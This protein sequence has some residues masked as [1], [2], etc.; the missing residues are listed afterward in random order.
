MRKRFLILALI[1]IA[2][3][4]LVSC[5]QG[6]DLLIP[7]A[8]SSVE[9]I[10]TLDELVAFCSRSGS[11]KA[12]LDLS[13]DSA[14]SVFPLN[15]TGRKE[16]SGK[17]NLLD[18]AAG[19][20]GLMF[21]NVPTP[22]ESIVIFKVEDGA[23]VTISDF[24]VDVPATVAEST[25]ITVVSMNN[26]VVTANNYTVTVTGSPSTPDTTPKVTGLAVGSQTA[27]GNVVVVNS[28]PGTVVVDENNT[29]DTAIRDNIT[30]SNP[31]SS[32][33]VVTKY[34]AATP[35]EF[36]NNLAEYGE[37]RLTAD[38][39]A[40]SI[41]VEG[42]D[43]Q[44]LIG[45]FT[46]LPEGNEYSVNLNG[47]S[48]QITTNYTVLVPSNSTMSFSDGTLNFIL[49]DA[50]SAISNLILNEGATLNLDNVDFVGNTAGI[51]PN[52]DSV[53]NVTNGSSVTAYSYGIATN[54][55][56]IPGTDTPANGDVTIRISNSRVESQNGCA[57]FLNVPGLLEIR[58]NSYI[59]GDGNAVIL[60]GGTGTIENSTLYSVCI[61]DG[62][63]PFEE[64]W[65]TGNMVPFAA[66]LIGNNNNGYKYPT[67]C[68]VTN[69]E[70]TMDAEG[71]DRHR[72]YIAASNGM[73]CSVTATL[74]AEYAE[75]IKS[76]GAYKIR[77]TGDILILNGEQLTE[78][79]TL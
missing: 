12:D 39:E 30:E 52:K 40:S 44:D 35:E 72:V 8:Q 46:S 27:P 45:F 13:V 71:S 17:L 37:V 73:E 69:T 56:T 65:S 63:N 33:D 6:S 68:T 9:N 7:P 41:V 55:S 20:S 5:S 10:T 57:V 43:N 29:N 66:L 75:E 74:P 42:E 26:S 60:R 61:Y 28:N 25:A 34:D 53:V 54:A 23:N 19:T 67:S 78:N 1:G 62:S 16:F 32:I 11:G 50:E 58:D 18:K 22:E 51:G 24:T 36:I 31:E 70:I 49:N 15:V 38:I 2:A 59:R 21:M 3:L 14:S 77:E 4:I 48:L 76:T 47:H 64:S 79:P